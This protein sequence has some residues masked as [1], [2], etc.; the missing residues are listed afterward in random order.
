[1]SLLFDISPPPFGIWDLGLQKGKGIGCLFKNER[2]QKGSISFSD[3]T[4]DMAHLEK[5]IVN[6][7][8][9]VHDW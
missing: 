5:D 1:M 6:F 4:S 3:V 8:V 7:H 9:A 2:A